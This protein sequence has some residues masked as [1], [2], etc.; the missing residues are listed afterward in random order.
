MGLSSAV[1]LYCCTCWREFK[2]AASSSKAVC[3]SRPGNS[4][5]SKGKYGAAADLYTEGITLD[6]SYAV[7]YV[8]RG[9]G[10]GLAPS[11]AQQHSMQGS[12]C[13]QVAV[14]CTSVGGGQS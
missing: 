6:P 11:I 9:M 1:L 10:S 12:S 7:L 8:N 13:M 2:A 5:F 3:L 14:A 4:L